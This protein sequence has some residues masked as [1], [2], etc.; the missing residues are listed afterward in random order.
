MIKAKV[1]S[2]RIVPLL[3]LAMSLSILHF[4]AALAQNT[5]DTLKQIYDAGDYQVVE[6]MAA[7][8]I[9][10]EPQN[11]LAHYYLA[12]ALAKLGKT[13]EARAEYT[14]CLGLGRGTMVAKNAA[15]AL[16]MSSPGDTRG[17]GGFDSAQTEQVKVARKHLI[18][19]EDGEKQRARRHFDEKVKEYQ[20]ESQAHSGAAWDGALKSRTQAAFE[21]LSQEEAA[22]TER[23]QKRADALFKPQAETA[24]GSS[25]RTVPQGS[26]MYVQ[27][28]ENLGD[29]SQAATIP[30]ENPLTAKAYRLGESGAKKHADSKKVQGQPKPTDLK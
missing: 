14:K 2:K 24:N 11:A 17:S 25:T 10:G 27:N 16:G 5:L 4:P 26:N 12:S 21:Q 23:Y 20:K 7:E 19:Q 3:A 6:K 29:E 9:A 1:K 28:F 8:V 15:V 22:I 18:D 13:S 30:A